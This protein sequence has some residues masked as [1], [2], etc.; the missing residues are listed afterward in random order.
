MK[1]I[2]ATAAT[3]VLLLGCVTTVTGDDPICGP[4]VPN[5]PA[6]Y[7]TYVSSVVTTLVEKAPHDL[8]FSYVSWYPN[9]SPGSAQGAAVCYTTN[10]TLC[11]ECLN[12]IGANLKECKQSTVGAD[13]GRECIMLFWEIG[14]IN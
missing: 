5:N 9:R 6:T 10:P 1:R 12:R 11:S 2:L 4:D 14:S 7:S 13:H 8:A 3:V